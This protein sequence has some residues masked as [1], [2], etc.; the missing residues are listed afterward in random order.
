MT[1]RLK[2]IAKLASTSEAT[3]SLVLN[4]RQYHRVSASL[5]DRIESI[6]EEVGYRPNRQAQ[7]LA[8]GRTKTIG[9]LVNTLTNSFFSR[10]VGLLEDRLGVHGYH[11]L[12]AE[13]RSDPARIGQL[14]DMVPQRVA[15]AVIS[16]SDRPADAGPVAP[17]SRVVQ[18]R[19]TF[20]GSYEVSDG[21]P[22]VLVDY[23]HATREMLEHLLSQGVT[24]LGLLMARQHDP[25]SERPS[26]RARFFLEVCR[27]GERMADIRDASVS[28]T[29]SFQEWYDA[30]LRLL[31]A[32]RPIDAMF[33]HNAHVA[34]PVLR[35][36]DDCGRVVGHDLAVVTYDDP[37]FAR[38]LGPGLSVVREPAE[39]VSDDLTEI[40]LA[41]L[42]GESTAS[43]V[44]RIPATFAARSSSRLR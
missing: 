28:E 36:I 19:E 16:L 35:A 4:G 21:S 38:W 39:L 37:E 40:A 5:R 17:G 29:S 3:V 31:R 12:P 8:S 24:R 44:R 7:R 18:R 23:S 9:V 11:V 22:S 6:A 15:D 27:A 30:A 42:A 26:A 2:D 43:V 41:V 32:D 14:F 10:Y 20:G 25:S 1:V 33:I 13:T 34:T